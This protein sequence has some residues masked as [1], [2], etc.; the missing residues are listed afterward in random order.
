MGSREKGVSPWTTAHCRQRA[1]VERGIFPK[2][3]FRKTKIPA[4]WTRAGRSLEWFNIG[5]CCDCFSFNTSHFSC[6]RFLSS[7]V[8]FETKVLE[9][10]SV[11]AAFHSRKEILSKRVK[12]T[13]QEYEE[14]LTLPS[15]QGTDI[16]RAL[17]CS[18]HVN[19]PAL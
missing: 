14:M 10:N 18:P 13:M 12:P 9:I 17:K 7:W 3:E 15:Y 5:L 6:T 16:I 4:I 2:K 8:L 1:A 19:T 11:Q